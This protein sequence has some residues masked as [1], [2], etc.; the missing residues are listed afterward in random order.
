VVA[1]IGDGAFQIGPQV[2]LC[3][4]HLRCLCTNHKPRMS[5][6]ECFAV[7]IQSHTRPSETMCSLW[8][9]QEIATVMRQRLNPIF[10]I[11]NNG[12]YA[13]EEVCKLQQPV[14]PDVSN[15]SPTAAC[16]ATAN[17][18]NLTYMSLLQM[19]HPGEYNTLKVWDYVKLADALSNNDGTTFAAKVGTS[20]GAHGHCAHHGA[21]FVGQCAVIMSD[22]R[23]HSK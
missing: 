7:N 13:V 22:C 9:E 11:L 18:G 3:R 17:A 14:Q 16:S 20:C 6:A 12:S 10:I 8:H 4:R 23:S 1:V 19:I 2:H 21:M 5:G 15:C